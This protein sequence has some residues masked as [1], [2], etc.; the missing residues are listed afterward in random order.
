M[1]SPEQKPRPTPKP[2]DAFPAPPGRDQLW[3]QAAVQGELDKIANLPED[4]NINK[5]DSTFFAALVKIAAVIKG[6]GRDCV[7][8]QEV[9]GAIKDA[10]ASYPELKEKEI[11]RQWRNAYKFA[12]PRYRRE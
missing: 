1:S 9:L 6:S 12:N 11:E 10:C 7:S 5:A 2:E 4:E 3:T 8:P